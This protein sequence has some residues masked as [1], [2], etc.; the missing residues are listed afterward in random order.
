MINVVILGGGFAGVS[1]ALA[2]GKKIKTDNI[3]VI[4]IDRNSYH[5]FTPSLYEVASCEEPQKNVGIPY[6]LIFDKK[7]EFI[8]GVVMK[9]DTLTQKILL[10]KERECEYDYLIFALGSESADFGI[11]GVKEFGLPLKTLRDAVAIKNALSNSKKI[12]IGGGGFSGTEI[13]CELASHKCDLDVTLIQSSSVL[14]KELGGRISKLAKERLEKSN[15]KLMLGERIKKIT[16]DIVELEEGETIPYDVFIWTGGVK[17]SNLLGKIEAEE[18]LLV[19]NFKNIFAAGDV[20][21]PG[22]ARKA[23]EMGKI[24]AE[25]VLLSI[26]GKPLLAFSYRNLGYLVPLGSHF[27]TF[28]MGKYYI[29]GILAYILQQLIFLRYLLTIM[30]FI[31]A[32]K[33]FIRFEKDLNDN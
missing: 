33:R 18:T 26:I 9:I 17:S 16:K 3:R 1:A 31:E 10:D 22:V 20:A 24:S 7:I 11:P 13:A 32:I 23:M 29:S 12:I 30:P 27:A 4:V 28:A 14:L 19:K 25:N 21:V 5:T 15:V 2:F 8:K 6:N